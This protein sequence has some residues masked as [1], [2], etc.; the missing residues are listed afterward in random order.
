MR[1][2]LGDVGSSHEDT[3]VPARERRQLFEARAYES[4]EIADVFGRIVQAAVA[5]RA[6]ERW[7]FGSVNPLPRE[8]SRRLG[9]RASPLLP[10]RLPPGEFPLLRH[11]PI[12]PAGR[13]SPSC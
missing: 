8:F 1:P 6:P 9:A 2:R 10:V 13:Q 5:Y 3:A 12:M 4:L 11:F 7:T